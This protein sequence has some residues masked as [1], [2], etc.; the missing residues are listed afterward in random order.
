MLLRAERIAA[1]SGSARRNGSFTSASAARAAERRPSPG[2]LAR[3][4]SSSSIGSKNHFPKSPLMPPP[5]ISFAISVRV[6]SCAFL[7][8]PLTTLNS[9]VSKRAGLPALTSS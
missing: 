3:H 5:C 2:N 7:S 6:V 8:A 9:I 1:S 4:F